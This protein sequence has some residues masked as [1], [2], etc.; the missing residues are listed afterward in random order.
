MLG[1][2]AYHE[3]QLFILAPLQ[4]DPRSL[5]N[6]CSIVGMQDLQNRICWT[7]WKSEFAE[8]DLRDILEIGRRMSDETRQNR[9]RQDRTGLN[10]FAPCNKYS[11]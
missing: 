4:F 6:A 9:I 2:S 11:F 3:A 10:R 7:F 5:G 8:Q 1:Y